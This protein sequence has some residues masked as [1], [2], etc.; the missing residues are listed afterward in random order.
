MNKKFL[1][2]SQVFM[3]FLMAA[4]MSGIMG[5][6]FSGPS[7]E[8]LARWP[9]QFLVAWPIAFALTMFAWPASMKLAGAVLRPRSAEGGSEAR[10]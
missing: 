2:I 5:L 7:L 9:L 8:W 6:I 3:T 4:L 1:F 10:R